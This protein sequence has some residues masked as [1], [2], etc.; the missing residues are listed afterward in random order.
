M[1]LSSTELQTDVIDVRLQFLF[2]CIHTHNTN[3]FWSQ[4]A[5]RM[6]GAELPIKPLMNYKFWLDL[7]VGTATQGQALPV[8]CDTGS[9]QMA[10]Q[11]LRGYPRNHSHRVPEVQTKILCQWEALASALWFK[12]KSLKQR[13]LSELIDSLLFFKV[14]MVKV[15]CFP[16][17]VRVS[18]RH[19]FPFFYLNITLHQWHFSKDFPA[20]LSL[21]PN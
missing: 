13:H 10:A 19:C 11:R 16:E 20:W 14:V 8:L 15:L 18:S 1:F 21:F 3:S 17:M 2:M 5:R 6:K 12:K 9:S 4:L 7:V